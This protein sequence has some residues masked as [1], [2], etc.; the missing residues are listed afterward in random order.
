MNKREVG[1]PC[2]GHDECP[3]GICFYSSF[4][5]FTP[6]FDQ[7][8]IKTCLPHPAE[9]HACENDDD[10]GVETNPLV[11]LRPTLDV[12]YLAPTVQMFCHSSDMLTTDLY[13][14]RNEQVDNSFRDKLTTAVAQEHV[15]TPLG[16]VDAP[17]KICFASLDLYRHHFTEINQ[18]AACSDDKQC[19][20]GQCNQASGECR[21]LNNERCTTDNDCISGVCTGSWFLFCA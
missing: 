8:A 17:T 3:S 1:E 19:L 2:T 13:D 15:W 21:R 7:L 4:F 11:T 18:I 12:G 6:H 10:C 14:L 20:S 5:H 9:F 16:Y